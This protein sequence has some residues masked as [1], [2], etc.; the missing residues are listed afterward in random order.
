MRMRSRTVRTAPWRFSTV[1][2]IRPFG[3]LPQVSRAIFPAAS[4]HPDI[5]AKRDRPKAPPRR[6]PDQ[7]GPAVS[8]RKRRKKVG[9]LFRSFTSEKTPD[10]F[11]LR[12]TCREGDVTEAVHTSRR[13]ITRIKSPLSCSS[14]DSMDASTR[15]RSPHQSGMFFLAMYVPSAA[16]LRLKTVYSPEMVPL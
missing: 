16:P 14:F 10:P 12:V 9:S 3:P 6:H 13:Y 15:D 2:A 1:R 5:L 8:R 7:P 11:S 4:R